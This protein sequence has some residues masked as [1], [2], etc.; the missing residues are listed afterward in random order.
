LLEQVL[1]NLTTL[2]AHR[3]VV[4]D[5]AELISRLSGTR[6]VW[7]TTWHR[8]GRAT[9]KRAREHQLAAQDVTGLPRGHAAVIGLTGRAH[10][11]LTRVLPPGA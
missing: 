10:A 9:R 3:Q 5:S 11:T 7:S 6:G 8:D 1:G 2:V 4:P